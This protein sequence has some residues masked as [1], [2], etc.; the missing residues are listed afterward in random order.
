MHA[1]SYDITASSR[2]LVGRTGDT[3]ERVDPRRAGTLSGGVLCPYVALDPLAH[4]YRFALERKAGGL[5]VEVGLS[6]SRSA[7]C[8]LADAGAEIQCLVSCLGWVN[9]I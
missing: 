1:L 9:T 8:R 5:G 4:I 3:V 2:A 6:A 7:G